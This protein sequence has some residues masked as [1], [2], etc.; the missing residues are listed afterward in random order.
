MRPLCSLADLRGAPGPSLLG[1]GDLTNLTC[2]A[3]VLAGWREGRW[4]S[5]ALNFNQLNCGLA[6]LL[7][8]FPIG[9]SLFPVC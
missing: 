1:T 4:P 2:S 8:L 3:G 7:F 9:Y 6:A 5:L